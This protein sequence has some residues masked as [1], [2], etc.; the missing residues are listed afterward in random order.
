VADLA[1]VADL[2]TRLGR[3]LTATEAARA[4]TL[5]AGVSARVRSYTGQQFERS[6]STARVRVR[7]GR[8]VLPQRPVSDVL[9]IKDVDG[10]NVPFTWH[11]GS[12]I[13]LGTNGYPPIHPVEAAWYG[14]HR[15]WVDVTYTHG[16][17]QLPADVV[18]VVCQMALRAFGADPSASSLG[19]ESV[20]GY[21]YS[22]G[23]AGAAGAVG[24]LNDEKAALDVY[25][26]RGGTIR[27][28]P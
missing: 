21:S 3:T 7:N 1:T 4:E 13:I 10:R 27:V 5:L 18:E 2:E 8:L 15:E 9:A 12:G 26:R 11:A 6:T 28:T 24:M 23:S 25:R 16:Y 19:Q 14:R 20:E 17:D 22:L